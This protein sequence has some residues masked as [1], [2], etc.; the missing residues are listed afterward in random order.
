MSK[1]CLGLTL[2]KIK[3]NR[4][5][6]YP[7][8]YCYNHR[9]QEIM[10]RTIKSTSKIYHDVCSICLCDVDDKDDCHLACGHL[11]HLECIK[12]VHKPECPVCRK[13]LIFN[14]PTSINIDQIK[15]KEKEFIK[16]MEN[17][18]SQELINELHNEEDEEDEVFK[19]A[20]E[21]SLLYQEIEQHEI[22]CQIEEE[23]YQAAQLK[24]ERLSKLPFNEWLNEV[25]EDQPSIVVKLQ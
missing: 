10:T 20:V 1:T 21:Q 4:H 14:Q 23:N 16:K 17:D 2:N 5:V 15:I 22:M 12:G 11:H 13:T 25:F 24:Q 3:C 6:K 18:S 7:K 8:Q 19:Q 9:N